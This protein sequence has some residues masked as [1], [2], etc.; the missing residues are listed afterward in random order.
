MNNSNSKN[1]EERISQLEQKVDRLSE[2]LQQIG[3]K[4]SESFIV[5]T[6][7]KKAEA[8]F[9]GDK[10]IPET[11]SS[12]FGE[13]WLNKIGLGLLLLGV[14]FLFKYTIDQ[15]WLVPPVRSLIG[16]GIGLALFIPGLLMKKSKTLM[17]QLLL[18]GG[19]AT[20]YITGF[21]TFQLYSFVSS[22]V[23][24]VFMI[25]VTLLS[26]SLS[27]QQNE[28]VL[29][30]VGILGGIGTPF[31]LYTGEGSLWE[32][33]IYSALIISGGGIIYLFKGWKSLL[34]TMIAGG[35]TVL[36]V[37]FYNN[38]SFISQP[39]VSDLWALQAGVLFYIIVLW[40]LPVY[41]CL[42]NRRN[43][44]YKGSEEAEKD[45]NNKP[46]SKKSN[47]APHVNAAV[48]TISIVSLIFSMGLWE[49]TNQIWGVIAMSAS[50]ITGYVYLPLRKKGLFRL[51][52][53]HGFTALILLTVS[54]FLLMEGELLFVVLALEGIGL[55]IA[56]YN[57][58]DENLSISSHI[59]LIITLYY[60]LANFTESTA[61][62]RA[63][64]NITGLT[65]LFVIA[66]G[67]LAVPYWLRDRE[68][69]MTYRLI[70]HLA[71][72]GWFFAE[73]R[74]LDNGQAFISASWGVYALTI[75][76]LG[77]LRNL[78][79]L[80]LAGMGTIFLVVGKLFLVDLSQLEALWRILLFIGFGALLL[81]IGYVIQ[82]KFN[83][84]DF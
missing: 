40:I 56:A 18:G 1:L 7:D 14:I 12:E 44:P 39:A 70:A 43:N 6:E 52:S 75:L 9:R 68:S 79:W 47:S 65:N 26:L 36:L 17:K 46:G 48:L 51:A 22:P 30:V 25:V 19:I 58:R 24:W 3:E 74:P 45:N 10:E 38:V 41:R 35:Y 64:L 21:A 27:L 5:N 20:F 53:V 60:L 55:R 42:P 15:G 63:V 31:M 61:D 33:I 2:Q 50:L 84:E 28:A 62:S 37:G 69:Q 49:F 57:T 13:N 32:L 76:V 77:Y 8:G 78:K 66:V 73:F 29:S 34:W 81:V 4:K 23:V 59:I 72:L 54:F 11:I 82:Q 71:L 83:I 67:G 80:R 16:L